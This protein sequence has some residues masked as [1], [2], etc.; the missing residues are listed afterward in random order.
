VIFTE[1]RFVLL[2]ALC[3]IA[4]FTVPRAWRS[5][6]LA[7]FGIVFYAM[8][9][10]PGVLGV[11][12]LLTVAAYVRA[13][14]L[15]F[16]IVLIVAKVPDAFGTVALG[17]SYL[18]FELI[19]VV[20]ERRRG[21][22]PDMSFTELLAF[23]FFAPARIAGPIK[24]FPQFR[25]AVAGAE[26][27]G[28]DVYAGVLRILL[29]LAKKFLLADV[30]ALTV[31]E[32]EYASSMRQAWLV[33]LAFGL[34]LFLDFSAYSDIAIG[35]ARTLGIRLPENFNWP[36][37]AANI[38]EFW[39]RW[40]ITLS[41]W[42]RDYVFT[43]LGRALFGTPLRPYP[44]AIATISY[45]V[46]FAVVGAWHGLEPRFVLWGLYHGALL[47]IF[48]VWRRYVPSSDS[49]PLRA[50]GIVTTF[51]F[52]TIG[53]VPFFLPLEK[54]AHMWALMFGLAR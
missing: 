6:T 4:F 20:V 8:F 10:G 29:G 27:S 46:T 18:T 28:D 51:F 30:L 47:S 3:W 12:L 39:E 24:R 34:Q 35:F 15:L 37:L 23:V 16:V 1:L 38:R 9:A 54:A 31:A 48:H 40:H 14:A 43:P 33:V 19:H 45:L 2:F 41:Q 21:R 42:V 32:S 25:D 50:L 49:R 5:A 26:L 7:A 11:V 52:V 17:L 44:A 53:W 13:P 36:Y 22:I